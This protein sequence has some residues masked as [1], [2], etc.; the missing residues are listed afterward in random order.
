MNVIR[1]SRPSTEL[2]VNTDTDYKQLY[3]RLDTV[4]PGLPVDTPHDEF[5]VEYLEFAVDELQL[6]LCEAHLDGVSKN[7]I[8]LSTVRTCLELLRGE[9][10]VRIEGDDSVVF[11]ES[12][13]NGL[14]KTWTEGSKQE[15]RLCSWDSIDSTKQDSCST[16]DGFGV[17]GETD[18][19]CVRDFV[20]KNPVSFI[21]V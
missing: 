13:S 21:K 5:V 10:A 15:S 1:F 9:Y 17:A 12:C 2:L 6:R 18:Y 14:F 8:T 3:E 7:S 4:V 19:G 16:G 11:I 20:N